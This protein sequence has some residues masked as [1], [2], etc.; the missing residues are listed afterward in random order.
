VAF[1]GLRIWLVAAGL[2]LSGCAADPDPRAG[3]AP[4]VRPAPIASGQTPV[5]RARPEART[6]SPA[7]AEAAG[8]APERGVRPGGSLRRPPDD[9]A[10][11]RIVV[12]R[13][14]SLSG[15]SRRHSVSLEALIESNRLEAP[16]RLEVGQMI[17][18]PPPN[19][20]RIEPGETLYSV[21]RRFSV[22]TR[23][24]AVMNGL[25]RPWRVWPGDEIL[26][27]PMAREGS[28]TSLAPGDSARARAPSSPAASG[29]QPSFLWPVSGPV[30][31][32]FGLRADGTRNEGLDFSVPAGGEVLAS[33]G[34]E[35]AYAGDDLAG[36]GNLILIRHEGG[37]VSA[38]ARLGSPLVKE[39]DRIRQGQA[40]ARG[41]EGPD[42]GVHFEIR[43]GGQPVDPALYLPRRPS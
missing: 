11:R 25:E 35:V 5:P 18:L 32:G 40:L 19:I 15:L 13:G 43:K 12:R 33:A 34:G 30:V 2:G 10:A 14:E 27:P 26:L 38:Y 21:S 36:L 17:V 4:A 23:S 37:W 41:A 29:T 16:Y 9:P 7:V 31:S 1:P 39:G 8:L 28:R 3:S 42:G 22:D 24:L 20:H 6:A